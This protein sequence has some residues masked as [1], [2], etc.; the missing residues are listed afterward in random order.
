MDRYSSVC[1][2][3]RYVLDGRG[4]EFRWGARLSAPFQTS[5]GAHPASYTMGT[6]FFS[7]GKAAGFDLTTHLHLAPRLKKEYSNNYIPL[8]VF[9]GRYRVNC[10]FTLYTYMNLIFVLPC[11]IDI[12]TRDDTQLDA[13]IAVY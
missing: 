6:G 4:I 2:A 3:T 7:G 12:N 9:V 5:P 11:I 1:I 13:T 10:I 8:W